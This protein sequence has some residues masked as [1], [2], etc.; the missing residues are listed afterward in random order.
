V[1]DA[2]DKEMA[3]SPD[4]TRQIREGLVSLNEAAGGNFTAVGSDQQIAAMTKLETTPFFGAM[5]GKTRYYF[6]N[7]KAIWP[8]FGYEG[9]SWDKGGYINRGF[10]DV[11]WTDG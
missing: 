7:N 5:A 4:L 2:I 10:N 9:S 6:Y 1:V 3:G 11:T 8:K